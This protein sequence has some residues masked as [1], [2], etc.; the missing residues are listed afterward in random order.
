MRVGWAERDF[1]RRAA[2]LV[3]RRRG[4]TRHVSDTRGALSPLN[5]L[6]ALHAAPREL[7]DEIIGTRVILVGT[8][9][10]ARVEGPPLVGRR[11]LAPGVVGAGKPLAT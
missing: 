8:V 5:S 2:G 9:V 7:G 11:V 4:Q 6:A 1:T 10:A 3:L